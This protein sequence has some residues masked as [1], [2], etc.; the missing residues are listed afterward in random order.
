MGD[1]ST[2]ARL[3]GIGIGAGSN[4]SKF[5]ALDGSH[6]LT[7]QTPLLGL[8]MFEELQSD[9]AKIS[10]DTRESKAGMDKIRLLIADTQQNMAKNSEDTR[11][12]IADIQ[13]SMAKSSEESKA[14]MIEMRQIIESLSRESSSSSAITPLPPPKSVFGVKKPPLPASLMTDDVD[15]SQM[16]TEVVNRKPARIAVAE[17]SSDSGSGSDGEQ[18]TFSEIITA[19]ANEKEVNKGNSSDEDSCH[20]QE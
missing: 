17:D 11:G 20:K 12:S 19:T 14:E 2:F 10:E 9:I 8:E 6:E 18:S 3:T 16:G 15:D 5:A 1:S 4:G 7:D 13:Q